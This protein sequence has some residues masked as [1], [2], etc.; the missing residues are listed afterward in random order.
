ALDAAPAAAANY[1]SLGD[2]G[3]TT[4]GSILMSGGSLTAANVL[5]LGNLGP[6]TFTQTG[7]TAN[8]TFT[9][10]L[11]NGTTTTSGTGLYNLTAGSLGVGTNE[12]IGYTSAGTL[13]QSGGTNNLVGSI[14]YLT[15]GTNTGSSGVYALSG[16][17]T[18]IA[19]TEYV[20]SG[21]TGTFNQTGGTNT[22]T[23]VLNLGNYTGI[24]GTYNLSGS[25]VLSAL[26]E[27]VG[28]GGPGI[29]NQ[30]G[31]TNMVT[32]T[33]ASPFVL[34]S[35]TYNLNAGSL[36]V[37]NVQPGP[38]AAGVFNLSGGT[39][40]ASAPFST[41]LA[42][43]L[44]GSGGGVT[45]N[46]GS[47]AVTF[48]GV[49]SGTGGMTVLGGGGLTL[50]A[51]NTYSGGTSIGSGSTLTLTNAYALP[52]SIV[53]VNGGNGLLLNTN[54]GANTT[55]YL[56]GLSGGGSINLTDSSSFSISNSNSSVYAV[57]L[58]VGAN[59][60]SSTFDGV[61]FGSGGLTKTGTGL[62]GLGG[63]NTY[64]GP[65][66][67]VASR[68]KLDYTQTTA[69]LSGIINYAGINSPLVLSAG[70]L[71]MQVGGQHSNSQYF[72]YTTINA[73]ASEITVNGTNALLI[74]GSLNR[75][76]GS[77]IDFTLPT[78]TQSITNCIVTNTGNN[79]G[80]MGAY[81]TTTGTAGA[82]WASSGGSAGF[83]T[84][85]Y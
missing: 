41:P 13:S 67:I 60:A 6:G 27:V 26:S 33:G 1:L 14:S 78:G 74:L 75:N 31:G 69:P 12:Y 48:S 42:L 59:G 77:T 55:F 7:G 30:T 40:A 45:V 71:L 25:G 4:S 9:L 80:I 51:S 65:T 29:F 2:T 8:V 20:G 49:L 5:Y 81:A 73:G 37:P 76:T 44:S 10:S 47:N 62:L 54:S 22:V 32:G 72:K 50:T 34:G 43:T 23:S 35:G 36:V 11:G 68:L 38:G 85:Y 15:L 79:N 53:T 24:N 66:T 52:D 84:P 16:T 70:T 3:S 61:L 18:L 57:T 46:T 82:T 56:A 19:P 64:S 28:N 17:G 58:N 39:L 63:E 21:G 83:I